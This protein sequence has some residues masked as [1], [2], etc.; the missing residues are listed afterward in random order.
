M[1]RKRLKF[2]RIDLFAA[3]KCD[4][5]LFSAPWNIDKFYYTNPLIF[6][7][8]PFYRSFYILSHHPHWII[9]QSLK[10]DKV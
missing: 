10:P 7:N 3:A 6:S 5:T 2:D 9:A 8:E 4:V 1:R